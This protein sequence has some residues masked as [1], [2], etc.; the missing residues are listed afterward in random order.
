[1]F[2]L[3]KK[4]VKKITC[5]H[6]WKDFSWYIIIQKEEKFLNKFYTVRV[7]EPYVCIHCK[8]RRDEAIFERIFQYNYEVENCVKN[9]QKKYPQ[10]KPIIEVNDEIADFQLVDREYLAIAGVLQ[11]KNYSVPTLES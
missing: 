7:Y 8:E 4:K 11:N 6:K 2:G 5:N 1:M 3:K 10:I 9:L